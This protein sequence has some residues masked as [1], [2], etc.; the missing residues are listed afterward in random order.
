MTRRTWAAIWAGIWSA[1]A[2]MALASAAGAA[3]ARFTP[4]PCTGD[5][6]GVA[7]TVTCGFLTVDEARG[8]KS[9]RR[10]V[11]PVAVVKALHPKSG[12]VP[13]VYLHGGPGG[14]TIQGLPHL[15]RGSVGKELIAQDQDWIYFDHRGSKLSVPE[16]NCGEA[17]L[18]DAG[19]L[20]E[21][22]AHTL[23]ACGQRHTAAGVDLS[24]YN[25]AETARDVR[26]LTRALGV[27]R[28]DI[29]GVS[30][31]TRVGFG[32]IVHAPQGV[33][34]VVLDSVWP[35]DANWAVGGPQMISNA[36]KLLFERCKA[37][38]ACHRAFPD[39]AADLDGVA[40]R[41]LA[42]PVTVKG[43]TYTV[44]DLGGFL[45][46]TIYDAEGARS[47]P[48]DVHAFATG[49]FSALNESI[50]T[51]SGYDEAQHLAFLCKERIPF[52]RKADVTAAPDDLVSQLTVASLRRYFDVC[53]SYAVGKPDP[54]EN[55][56]VTSA[57]PTLFLSAQFDPGCPPELAQAAVKRF[58]HGQ[59]VIVPNTTHGVVR[60]S[61]CGRKM[62]RAFLADPSKP[63]DVGCL[64]TDPVSF[65]F[66][67]K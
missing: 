60:N 2:G 31:G 11:L 28:Y 4:S 3:P 10:V 41:F 12:A 20:S 67:L 8:S 34:A 57:L 15:L 62:I 52:E 47:L 51:R 22:T 44:D 21:A 64:K 48:R 46:D 18:T 25:T 30:Y 14:S 58:A 39:P 26:D 54:V 40:R 42:G 9:G 35:A 56:P 59:L 50:A 29:F 65:D 61:P 55:R 5:F 23:E 32:V 66:A 45:M 43:R 63:V 1:A 38:A 13:V 27:K 49:D 7:Q 33:R 36:A 19:P 37:D 53:K 24:R 17:D 16:L 6:T